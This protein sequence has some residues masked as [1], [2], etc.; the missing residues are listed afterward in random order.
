PLLEGQSEI[1]ERLDNIRRPKVRRARGPSPDEAVWLEGIK[2]GLEG[3]A[4][5]RFLDSKKVLVRKE[6]QDELGKP[7]KWVDAYRTDKN[8]IQKRKSHLASRFNIA[9]KRKRTRK[10]QELLT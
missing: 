8:Y 3:P 10:P 4:F 5:C 7:A 6:L 1:K 2:S 9:T